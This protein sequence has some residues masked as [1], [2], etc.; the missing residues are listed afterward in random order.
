MAFPFDTA[1]VLSPEAESLQRGFSELRQKM[2]A[3]S[4]CVPDDRPDLMVEKEEWCR[5]WNKISSDIGIFIAAGKDK[6]VALALTAEDVARGKELVGI[7]DRFV[8]QLHALKEMAARQAEIS[9]PQGAPVDVSME[10]EGD[11]EEDADGE[12]E[13]PIKRPTR[14]R[15]AKHPAPKGDDSDD[16]MILHDPPC[17]RCAKRDTE[18]FGPEK[19]G[20]TECRN[21]KQACSYSR[22][23]RAKGKAS[24]RRPMAA[25]K[26]RVGSSL[27]SEPPITISDGE[28]MAS[29]SRISKTK[30]VV[31]IQGRKR[32]LA[33]V[34]EEDF[35]LADS[36][37]S[38]E[39]LILAGK[40][41][42]VYAKFR[43]IQGLM[44]EVANELDMMQA[45]VTKKARF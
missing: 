45:H 4:K 15:K 42:G 33:D 41:R 16:G 18:C 43:T 35:A 30:P 20:C 3:E 32:K 39:D 21:S 10:G 24:A 37:L 22:I 11:E 38:G 2:E 9:E 27:G 44:S 13:V 36:G 23:A 1:Q 31:L 14:V 5:R 19:R 26:V 40:L 8:E 6:G 34:E 28:D 7:H 17:D 12:S 29:A 25:S